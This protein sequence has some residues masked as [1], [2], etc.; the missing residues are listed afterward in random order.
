MWVICH[1][2]YVPYC[3]EEKKKNKQHFKNGGATIWPATVA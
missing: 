2:M 3:I 1:V